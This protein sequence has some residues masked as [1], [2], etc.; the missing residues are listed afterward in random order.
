MFS[1]SFDFPAFKRLECSV[2]SNRLEPPNAPFE[3]FKRRKIIR[4]TKSVNE[5]E[6]L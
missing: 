1:V 5:N 3:A 4:Q 6:N 2:N